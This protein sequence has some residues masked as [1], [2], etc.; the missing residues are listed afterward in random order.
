M[1][2]PYCRGQ[3]TICRRR[4]RSFS[5]DASV[6]VALYFKVGCMLFNSM[7]SMFSAPKLFCGCIGERRLIFQGWMYVFLFNVLQTNAQTL[8]SL[9]DGPSRLHTRYCLVHQYAVQYWCIWLVATPLWTL[10]TIQFGCLC[11]VVKS[12]RA[13]PISNVSGIIQ[14]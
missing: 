5:A 2:Q 9:C 8:V 4:S 10:N 14:H 6:S 7:I 1:L 3:F 13:V 11:L 12:W